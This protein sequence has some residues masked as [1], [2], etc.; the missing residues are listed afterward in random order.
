MTAVLSRMNDMTDTNDVTAY[1]NE[2]GR[3][4][5][6]AAR[7]LA[8]ASTERKNTALTA[9]AQ[10]LRDNC[11]R[12]LEANAKDVDS[13]KAAGK[14]AAFIDR[15][16]LDEER[17][18]AIADALDKIA[19][20]PD[21][22]GRVLHT[23]ERPNGLTIE[24]VATPLGVIG[25]IYES[26]PNVGADAGALCLKS[27]NAVILRGGSES[28][29]STRVIVECLAKGLEAADLPLDCIQMIDTTDRD[30]VQALLTC[31]DYVDLVIPRG[32]KGLVSLVRDQARVPTLLHLDGNCHTYVH[33]A[34]DLTKAA[35]II[36]NAKLRRTGIC[37]ATESLVV[38]RKVAK[39]FLPMA[40]DALGDCE[41]R[42]E[43]EA[44]EIDSRIKP[45]TD[46]DFYTEYLD[47]ILSVK[48]VDGPDEAIPFVSEH[49]S[50][51]TDAIVTEDA[52]VAERFLNE[53]DS[54]VVM[55]NASTQ[56]SDGGE[57]GMGAE[58][59]IAT[60]KMHARGPV[61]LEQ[62]TSFKYRVRGNGQTRP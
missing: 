24:R 39:D 7:S 41:V 14:P 10:A 52:Q 58:I 59:G 9:A 31:A 55:H 53:I 28:L 1:V 27:G 42:G 26:R 51:H 57:F 34:A 43:A 62:L 25:M 21:P 18:G 56:F 32:G 48:L 44:R 37:G 23:T 19:E 2:L 22:V 3:R 50:A 45:A 36:K 38:D 60:G 20:L 16:I 29:N 6:T 33:A 49:S 40:M 54:A 12:L 47:T 8:S 46:E 35:A 17:V 4:A 30:A 61:G 5:A 13:V 15:L 11:G